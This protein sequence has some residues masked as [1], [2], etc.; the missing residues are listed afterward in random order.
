MLGTILE[1]AQCDS[2]LHPAV[3]LTYSAREGVTTSPGDTLG[4]CSGYFISTHHLITA[5]HAFSMARDELYAIGERPPHLTLPF[6]TFAHD[7]RS[8]LHGLMSGA[9]A[10]A[11]SDSVPR[12]DLALAAVDFREEHHR[13]VTASQVSQKPVIFRTPVHRGTQIQVGE[14]VHI[15]GFSEINAIL[16]SA[17]S[18]MGRDR[19]FDVNAKGCLATGTV[20]ALTIQRLGKLECAAFIIY[21]LEVTGQM[22][23]APV[24]DEG[25]RVV[26]VV[27]SALEGG[28]TTTVIDWTSLL[29]AAGRRNGHLDQILLPGDVPLQV[30]Y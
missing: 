26:G 12:T 3:Y 19:D 24:F 13:K 18:A 23:G 29:A 6:T 28:G 27:S 9:V 20:G 16:V 22:S 25:D 8:D 7:P 15:R 1:V 30:V 2:R 10:I 21:N 5:A 4:L 17:P 11:E 14:L